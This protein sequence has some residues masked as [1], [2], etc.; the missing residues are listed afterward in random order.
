MKDEII[1]IVRCDGEYHK[2][3]QDRYLDCDNCS[4]CGYSIINSIDIYDICAL[5][6]GCFRKVA[7]NEEHK[8]I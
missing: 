5:F 4:L 7:A 8:Q 3:N 6:P 1:I 2:L